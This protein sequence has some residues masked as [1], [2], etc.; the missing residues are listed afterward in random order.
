MHYYSKVERV[1]SSRYLT[2]GV[3]SKRAKSSIPMGSEV[4]ESRVNRGARKL[5]RTHVRSQKSPATS[6]PIG[7]AGPTW[8]AM[9]ES[10]GDVAPT[11]RFEKGFLVHVTEVIVKVEFE[12]VEL[13][14]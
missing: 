5:V 3:P 9:L 10:S 6:M 7:R 13:K 2:T 11:R 8:H 14:W 12:F 1:G 4:Q